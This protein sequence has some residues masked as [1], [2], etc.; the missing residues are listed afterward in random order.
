LC[1]EEADLSNEKVTDLGGASKKT[2]FSIKIRFNA[3]TSVALGEPI[4]YHTATFLTGFF[5]EDGIQ[6]SIFCA[7]V[8]EIG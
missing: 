1:A 7:S 2:Y 4:F 3:Q 8:S 6:C 5:R